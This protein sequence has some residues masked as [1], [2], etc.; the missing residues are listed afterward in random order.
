MKLVMKIKHVTK[1]KGSENRYFKF[2]IPKE[3]RD[4]LGGSSQ[5]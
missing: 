2:N 3:C 4:Q 5:I 1:R